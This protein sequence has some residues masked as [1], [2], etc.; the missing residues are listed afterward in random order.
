MITQVLSVRY[1]ILL[2]F[3]AAATYVHLRGRVRHSVVRQ[4]TDHSTVMAP[5]NVVMYMFSKV[6][7][8]PYVDVRQFPELA[9]LQANWETIRDEAVKL[10]DEG[11]IRAAAS[12]N[13]LG[14]NSFFKKGWKRFY[15][16]WYGEFLP[17]GRSLCPRTSEL[18]ARMPS[19][20]AAMFALLP[21]GSRLP[22][23][24]D[25]FG[26][27]LRYH[28]GLQTPNSEDCC[29]VVDGETYYWKDGEAVMFDETYIH[30]AQNN[31]DVQRLILFCDIERPLSNPIARAINRYLGKPFAKAAATQNLPGEKVGVLNKAFQYVYQ[32]RVLGK[33]IR[34][35]SE[36]AYQ[37]SK[38]GLTA[39]VIYGI[40]FA[41]R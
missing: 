8:T 20:N 16:K 26:G 36:V 5:Y 9:P 24:R 11:Y 4:I 38:W 37:V 19:V 23:H 13:D 27:S 29:I 22:K 6:K 12:Y 7:A 32:I 15:L 28:L 25:P 30:Y 41:G 1:L 2:A 40:F 34:K 31:T 33:A 14:F 35:R 10:F 17:S 18:L 21:P 3:I 39:L